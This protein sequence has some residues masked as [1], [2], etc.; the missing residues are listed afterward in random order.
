MKNNTVYTDGSSTGNGRMNAVGGIGVFFAPGDS[1]NVSKNL[2]TF[3]LKTFPNE[4]INK[5]TNNLAELCAILQAFL[6]LQSNLDNNEIVTIVSDSMYSINSL[7]IWYL[8]W[9]KN[10]WMNAAK[11]PVSNKEVI[12][13]IVDNYILK[14]PGNIKFRHVK[15]H[16]NGGSADWFGNQ[17]ADLLATNV[18]NLNFSIK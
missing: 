8:K 1:K 18:E 12:S 6:I 16:T 7:S 4:K 5:S 13:T 9:K 3:Y 15:A 2:E 10:G 14:Y 11:K 17:Q